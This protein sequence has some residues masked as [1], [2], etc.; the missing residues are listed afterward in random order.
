[1]NA[2]TRRFNSRESM[3][4]VTYPKK[5]SVYHAAIVVFLEFFAFGLLTSPMI[6]VLDEAFPKHTFLM[7][8]LIQGVKGFL[9]FLSAPLIGAMSDVF[10]RKPFLI[11]TVTFTCSPLP[12]IKLS[13]WWYFTMVSIS[14]I[15]AVTF[16]IVLA[17]VSDITTEE[18]RGWA[19]GLVSATFAASLIIS[20]TLGAILEKAY[21]ENF[22]IFL[23]TLVA[24]SD[25]LFII[26]FVPESLKS[27][28]EQLQTSKCSTGGVCA[29]GNCGSSNSPLGDIT[30]PFLNPEQQAMTLI[31]TQPTSSSTELVCV[32]SSLQTPI[33]K[34]W[35]ITWDKVDPFAAL[36]HIS[37]DRVTL[38][39]C[40]TTFLS[41]LPEAGEY[42]C[43]FVYLRLVMNFTEENVALF[44]AICGLFSCVA[45]TCGMG[46]LITCIGQKHAIIVGLALEACQLALL[47]FFSAPWILWTAGSIAGLGSI[48]YP[49]LSAFLS[50]HVKSDQQG[51]TQGLLTGIRGLCGGLGPA[52]YGLIFFIFQVNLNSRPANDAVMDDAPI[53]LANGPSLPGV[54]DS[55]Q[56]K[57]QS[58]H[59]AFL[60][61]P[62]FAFGSLLA[63]LAI[64][65]AMFIPNET[66]VYHGLPT[67]SSKSRRGQGAGSTSESIMNLLGDDSDVEGGEGNS[68]SSYGFAFSSTERRRHKESR[69]QRQSSASKNLRQHPPISVAPLATKLTNPLRRILQLSSSRQHSHSPPPTAAAQPR[70]ATGASHFL[71]VSDPVTIDTRE[72]AAADLANFRVPYRLS[73]AVI[74]DTTAATATMPLLPH[75][76][77]TTTNGGFSNSLGGKFL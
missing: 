14:G 50:N 3:K 72:T 30:E 10:G 51:L 17:F 52:V 6:S 2:G 43:F 74:G 7:N 62:P 66:P 24:V 22:V 4:Q 33:V 49:A 9:S 31:G 19:Y 39:V 13:H 21:S 8:G 32:N 29:C 56:A 60:P 41:Y 69:H 73:E 34:K 59:R 55:F 70:S 57:L 12:F 67:S 15:F 37:R 38:L 44:I 42:S 45:Q 71:G 65:T 26:F 18:H 54:D 53:P 63:L 36:R 68:T 5:P 64:L 1:M 16:S 48:T 61:G 25:I 75:S 77:T 11:L 40:M 27:K 76:T 35:A 47:G 58:L 46:I 20:P 23:A 28:R